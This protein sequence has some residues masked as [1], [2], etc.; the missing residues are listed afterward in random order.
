M[1]KYTYKCEACEI[2][3]E[4]VR[5]A[6]N[7]DQEELC[8][9]CGELLIRCFPRIFKPTVMDKVN[10]ERNVHQ[11]KDHDVRVRKRAKE[12]FI[13]NE[14]PDL[15]EKHGKKHAE[16]VGWIKDGKIVKKDDLK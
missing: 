7:R 10:T 11:R 8:K 1:P 14:M 6:A 2:E 4:Q 3:V 13:E 16:K 15:I 12:Y 9:D 5:E